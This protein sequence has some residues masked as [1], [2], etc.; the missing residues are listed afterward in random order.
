MATTDDERYRSTL[1][2]EQYWVT[3]QKGTEPP[4]SGVYWN[5]KDSGTYRCVCCD[6]PLFSSEAKYDSGSGWP[7]FW[8]PLEDA[9]LHTETDH[10]LGM[11]RTEVT[12][13][14][15]GAHLGHI[16]PDGP[17]PTGL[18]YCLNSASLRLDTAQ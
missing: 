9:P 13:N 12:C 2:E 4:F 14:A 3:R 7:S 17:Q 18:R 8:A 1:T 6:A 10:T 16:F 5:T 11:E 15:C